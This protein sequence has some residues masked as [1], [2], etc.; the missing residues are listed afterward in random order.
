M[1]HYLE[2]LRKKPEADRRKA[3]FMVS[4]STTLIIAIIWII[5]TSIRIAHTDFSFDTSGIDTRVPSIGETF[6]KFVDRM[7]QVFNNASSTP[8]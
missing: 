5:I 8:Q 7:G 2:N 1:L 6:N 3:I 4:L